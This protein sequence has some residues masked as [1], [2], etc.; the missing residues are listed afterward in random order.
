M[1]GTD[2]AGV[3]GAG[4]FFIFMIVVVWQIAA[5]WRARM[6]AAREAQYKQLTLKYAQLLE[7][8][9][10]IQRR[11]MEE[12]TQARLSIASMEKMMREIE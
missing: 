8:N 9:V 11:S 2:W 7:D 1:N 12:L 5:T 10:E 6:L 3:A 4:G